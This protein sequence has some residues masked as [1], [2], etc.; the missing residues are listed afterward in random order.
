MAT[1][2]K[3]EIRKK[4]RQVT[5]R[6]SS[7]EMTDTEIDDR[8]NKFYQFTFPAEVK[9][10]RNHTFY[11]FLTSPNQPF[12]A[13]PDTTYT[14]FEPPAMI[15]NQ[16]ISW[17]Q[18]PIVFSQSS[19]MNIVYLTPWTGNG[20]IANF[21]I[22]LDP[23]SIYPGTLVITDDVEV[24]SDTNTTWTTSNIVMSGTLGGSATV[25]YS[26]GVVVVGFLLPPDSGQAI[27]LSYTECQTSRPS[28]V[29]WYDN[30]FQF[31]PIP[32]TA[33]RFKVKAYRVLNPLVNATDRPLLDQWGP[34][35]AYGTAR[36]IMADY[37]EI[38]GYAE[39]TALYKEQVAYVMNRTSQNLLNTRSTPDF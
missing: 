20:V 25:N 24:F 5:G 27:L 23:N 33:Y 38:D 37:S 22:T 34:C 11:E 7:N 15:D 30:Q 12:Y 28:S 32:D 29:L 8:I 39:V 19:S 4:V 21:T 18:D 3:A 35:I 26:T 9:L 14:N 16:I 1:W 17:S 36:D 13:A 31:F 10:E 2:T 6:L